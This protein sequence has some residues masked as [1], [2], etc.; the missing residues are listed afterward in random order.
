MYEQFISQ[1]SDNHYN[2]CEMYER[3]FDPAIKNM[4]SK[5]P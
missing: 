3:S 1:L 5:S 2:K 4:S